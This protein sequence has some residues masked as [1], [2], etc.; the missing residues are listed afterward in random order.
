[1][2]WILVPFFYCCCSATDRVVLTF[3]SIKNA[4]D[5]YV[6]VDITNFTIV[7]QYGRR[8]L[9]NLHR[10]YETK[11]N[12]LLKNIYSSYQIF[13]EPDAILSGLDIPWNLRNDEP[14][15]IKIEN[16]WHSRTETEVVV[17]VIDSGI[18]ESSRSAFQY[19][20]QGYDFI[21][22][23]DISSDGDGRDPVSFDPGP[24]SLSCPVA[25]WHGTKV[26]SIIAAQHLT[27]VY[28][29][30]P[31]ATI[32]PL[33]VL[34]T[35]SDGY[36]NDVTDAIVWA[37]GG[38][39]NGVQK[40][41]RP[42][43]IISL[44]LGGTGVC[45]DYMQSAINLAHSLGS[46]ILS[47]AGN[48]GR[49]SISSTFPAN[50]MHVISVGAMTR[51]G[52]VASYSNR[53]ASI[54]APGGD[55][56]NAIA[57]ISNSLKITLEYGT[58]FAVPHVAGVNALTFQNAWINNTYDFIDK[59]SFYNVLLPV[60]A[61]C[62][63][64]CST[65]FYLDGCT[66]KPCSVCETDKTYRYEACTATTDTICRNCSTCGSG[67]YS[68]G[69][70]WYPSDTR[71]P[72]KCTDTYCVGCSACAYNQ[73]VG[74]ACAGTQDTLCCRNCV[75]GAEYWYGGFCVYEKDRW[76]RWVKKSEATCAQCNKCPP[77]QYRWSGCAGNYNPYD[78]KCTSCSP[79]TYSSSPTLNTYCS[80][81]PAG[82]FQSQSQATACITC[83]NENPASL[84]E[85]CGFN[86]IMKQQC[87]PTQDRVCCVSADIGHYKLS[88]NEQAAC[89]TI[90]N[91][92]Y[93]L[94]NDVTTNRCL[95]LECNE[96]YYASPSKISNLNSVCNS[97]V[98]DG[99]LQF[100]LNPA[101]STYMQT[102]C[103]A[104]VRCSSN[105]TLLRDASNE[106]VLDGDLNYICIPCVPCPRGTVL[107][108]VCTPL[109]QT[110]CAKCPS[111]GIYN[112]FEFEGQCLFYIP[113][114]TMPYS[115]QVP[116]FITSQIKVDNRVTFPN[117]VLTV[118]G[119]TSVL[120]WS[121]PIH[122]HFLIPCPSLPEG[123]KYTNWVNVPNSIS[124]VATHVQNISY[125]WR[126]TCN[127]QNIIAC[128]ALYFKN[129][130]GACQSCI[131][132][133]EYSPCPWKQFKDL[134]TCAGEQPA[135][136][137]PCRGKLPNNA[138][139][140]LSKSPFYFGE[141]E[142][143]PCQW[144]CIAGY[145]RVNNSC[146]PCTKPL[147]SNF[148]RGPYR[149]ISTNSSTCLTKNDCRFFGGTVSD[150]CMFVCKVGYTLQNKTCVPIP[151]I[152]CS[153]GESKI[154]VS[155]A[156]YVCRSCPVHVANA[157]MFS[158]CTFRCNDGFYKKNETYCRP[159]SNL[160]CPDKFYSGNCSGNFDTQCIPCSEC[161][162][163][164]LIG[165]N[166]TASTDTICYPCTT[167]L[168]T[169]TEFVNACKVQCI[170]NHV[171]VNGSCVRCSANDFECPISTR[172]TPN[173][174]SNNV[175]CIPCTLPDTK[176]WCWTPGSVCA[177]DCLKSFRKRSNACQY[178][179][180]KNWNIFCVGTSV[181]AQGIFNTTTHPTLISTTPLPTPVPSTTSKYVDDT[182]T[183]VSLP[184]WSVGLILLIVIFLV[185]I[186]FTP[187][188]VY[189]AQFKPWRDTKGEYH[190]LNVRISESQTFIA[191]TM[192]KDF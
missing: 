173:C 41:Q 13:V 39:I 120:S 157:I 159:C 165:K 119:Y 154:L 108:S 118:E 80:P 107:H 72:N 104:Y 75:D 9:L 11:D 96:G 19:L 49:N 133:H 15:S 152:S 92:V 149:N 161:P 77:G 105:Q 21:S 55:S 73:H 17:A 156:Y 181:Q 18:S 160:Q 27:G 178:D 4:Q 54:L 60:T 111:S 64:S 138:E 102:I 79:G 177:W 187:C 134:T 89:P 51:Y 68:W 171:Q 42:A 184:D 150:G 139:F 36:S 192:Q 115:L 38:T 168:S 88:C 183:P 57:V 170:S 172:Y 179:A 86:S 62:S 63:S 67:K 25:S 135:L 94:T 82:K 14:F 130:S 98:T 29:I 74:V 37:A 70:C 180:S 31:N 43:N 131:H 24:V 93:L 3:D 6:N 76:N 23:E 191:A 148:D 69:C 163:G 48:D 110:V 116:T 7:K 128:E 141:E 126:P 28:G 109:Q 32:L 30:A 100:G 186:S 167:D 10:N 153:P 137:R 65:N 185:L 45:P 85:P 132:V 140:T 151:D 144:D 95:H 155:N 22:D 124:I 35:C 84:L 81:C 78:S 147:N 169:N 1:M 129:A 142:S 164:F 188:Y 112:A 66:C 190:I 99:L 143:S 113:T 174:T 117:T 162:A 175:G 50:C 83:A 145:Y 26:A 46:L 20:L 122:L 12:E 176:N 53:G 47:A 106:L 87:T 103:V 136:C 114:G 182:A 34:G 8:I 16:L 52:T 2:R 5:A 189:R 125:E 56:K 121:Q 91:G 158:D 71:L 101:C 59:Y 40:N 97:I 33:R 166:C 58:S 146:M 90:S 61:T 44:S 127:D 123:T